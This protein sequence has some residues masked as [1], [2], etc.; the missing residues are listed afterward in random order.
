MPATPD[1]VAVRLEMGYT[2][3]EF[4]RRL[5]AFADVTHDAARAR[6]D[7]VEGDRSWSLRLINPRQRIIASVRLPTVDVELVFRG[8]ARAEIVT[9][10]ARFHAWFRRG[11][12]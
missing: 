2:P 10:M 11:G 6:F 8:Y 3:A 9:F 1:G 4:A 7:H 12:G 5:E